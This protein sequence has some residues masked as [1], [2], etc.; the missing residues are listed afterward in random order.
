MLLK[1]DQRLFVHK[2]GSRSYTQATKG[3]SGMGGGGTRDGSAQRAKWG[4][5]Q[6]PRHHPCAK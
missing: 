5:L 6:P 2:L 3:R 4:G 1:D